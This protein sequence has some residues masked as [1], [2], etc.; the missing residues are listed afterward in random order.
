M[1]PVECFYCHSPSIPGSLNR[2]ISPCHCSKKNDSHRIHLRCLEEFLR[3]GDS[4]E[5]SSDD[6]RCSNCGEKFKFRLQWKFQLS[7]EK[8]LTPKSICHA[9]EFLII[10]FMLAISIIAIKNFRKQTEIISNSKNN[11]IH[12]SNHITI[13]GKSSEPDWIIYL[14][15]CSVMIL[16]PITLRK[17]YQRWK[18]ANS[19]ANI[20]EM[21]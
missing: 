12:N 5:F 2:L 7:A 16:I 17:V 15:F 11:Q 13:G 20:I 8:F 3:L 18:Q 1:P 19:E 4:E 21:V 14:L 10:I 6:R 9:I